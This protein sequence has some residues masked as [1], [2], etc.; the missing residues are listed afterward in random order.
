[1]FIIFTGVAGAGKTTVGKLLAQ[2]LGWQFY[3]GDDF[4]PAA[5]IEKMRRGEALTDSNRAP[6]LA[7]LRALLEQVL[8]REE[9]GILACSAL[10]RSY[11]ARLRVDERVIFVHL[12]VSRTLIERR[13][14]QRKDH[15]INPSLTESQF[16]TLEPPQAALTL[17][18]SLPP[19]VLVEQVR[20]A[21][22][23]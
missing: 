18:A 19:A 15:F 3:E 14:K 2:E 22:A 20:K 12:A 8:Q 11:R 4:H 13:L 7:R 6:W 23:I 9:P 1:M 16:D 21:L 17:D 5:N 10:K